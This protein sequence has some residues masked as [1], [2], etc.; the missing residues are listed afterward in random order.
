MP[1][2][3]HLWQRFMLTSS[4]LVGL[5][6]GAGATVFG[7]SN[8][9]TVNVNFSVLHINGVPLWTVAVVPLVFVLV[10]GTLYHWTDS[11]H[12]FTEHMRHRRRVHEL[13]AEVASLRA[14]L[15]QVL[16]MP[17]QSDNSGS[18]PKPAVA[19]TSTPALPQS[20]DAK[21]HLPKPSRPKRVTLTMAEEPSEPAAVTT[22]GGHETPAVDPKP[23]T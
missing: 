3:S 6:V 18:E 15:D 8:L 22:N 12:H 2:L 13:E 20:D 4:L 9:S 21:N 16:D 14:H 19:E 11:L 10:V 7:Y 5:V 23:E 1:D 17:R